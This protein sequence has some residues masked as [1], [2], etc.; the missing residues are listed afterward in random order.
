MAN[1][2]HDWETRVKRTVESGRKTII[3]HFNVEDEIIVDK[4]I[5][6]VKQVIINSMGGSGYISY[7]LTG[8]EFDNPETKTMFLSA[9]ELFSIPEYPGEAPVVD[10]ENP[11]TVQEYQ[12][13]EE[14]NKEWV[15]WRAAVNTA[16]QSEEHPVDVALPRISLDLEAAMIALDKFVHKN[17][18]NYLDSKQVKQ[19]ALVK[20]Y[21]IVLDYAHTVV[22]AKDIGQKDETQKK[23][24]IY[25]SKWSE[26]KDSPG[27][28]L[29]TRELTYIDDNVF[30][31]GSSVATVRIPFPTYEERYE[32]L[33]ALQK[34][35]PFKL[36]G[37]TLEDIARLSS[38]LSN[39]HVK[40]LVQECVCEDKKVTRDIVLEY[41]HDVISDELAG[42]IEFVT[43]VH[44]FEVIGGLDHV[45][46]ELSDVA[47][48]ITSGRDWLV[49]MGILLVGPP[50]TGKTVVAEAF[51]KKIAFTFLKFG[52]VKSKWV[53]DSERNIAKV[54]EM[55][56][57]LAPVVIFMDEIDQ[58]GQRGYEGD[59]G[60]S[61]HIFASILRTMSDTDLR[62]KIMWIAATN[63]PDLMDAA[64]KRPGR[65]D[66]RIPLLYPDATERSEIFQAMLRKYDLIPGRD[67]DYVSLAKL[68]EDHNGADIESIVLNAAKFSFR[69]TQ[70]K[71][72]NMRHMMESVEDYLAH[73]DRETIEK[74]TKMALREASSIRLLPTKYQ[75]AALKQKKQSMEEEVPQ[76]KVRSED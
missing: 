47:D 43:P 15:Q 4:E 48:A 37:A 70:S 18:V 3:S 36:N 49:P 51:A 53:G 45:K 9:A 17:T 60:V 62:G 65:F 55:A 40:A 58:E 27:I 1:H 64:M 16:E 21:T 23:L 42:M 54:F 61:N 44:G 26:R 68:T 46:N 59:G 75:E 50:G 73:H 28:V 52:N 5:I 39:K 22:P 35:I 13:W 30:G 25:L 20:D 19:E 29:L 34:I 74:Q 24:G 38:G 63:R 2:V 12:E 56:K 41:K 31:R 71:T 10:M 66:I 72:V 32:Y 14:R 8:F 69:E 67:L 76:F 7:D 11:E 57:E 6:P 33:K